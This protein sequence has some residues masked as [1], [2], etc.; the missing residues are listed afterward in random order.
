MIKKIYFKV[1]NFN[2]S[3]YITKD[4][5]FLLILIKDNIYMK[6]ENFRNCFTMVNYVYCFRKLNAAKSL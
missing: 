2:F 3:S 6:I 5:H 4:I 1:K